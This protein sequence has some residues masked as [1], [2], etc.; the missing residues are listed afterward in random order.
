MFKELEWQTFPESVQYQQALPMYK[1]LNDLACPYMAGIFQY[2]KDT[3]RNNLRSATNDK[4]LSQES[5]LK[6]FAIQ[7]QELEIS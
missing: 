3:E 5:T 6:V 4:L 2:V 7:A 1:S